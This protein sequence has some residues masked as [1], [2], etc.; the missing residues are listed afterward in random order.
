MREEIWNCHLSDLTNWVSNERN[1]H[2]GL[3]GKLALPPDE[4]PGSDDHHTAENHG[5]VK[6]LTKHP[7]AQADAE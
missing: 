7:D 6:S 5:S 2:V 1:T 4:Q 3:G